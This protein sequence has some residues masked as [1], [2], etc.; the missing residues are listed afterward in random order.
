[1]PFICNEKSVNNYMLIKLTPELSSK[2]QKKKNSA[3]KKDIEP[4]N[5]IFSRCNTR[6]KLE[7]IPTKLSIDLRKCSCFIF[8]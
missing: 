7:I 4:I 6:Y 8:R 3:H 2:L 1:M 5:T